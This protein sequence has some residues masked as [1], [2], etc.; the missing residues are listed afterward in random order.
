MASV[1][2]PLNMLPEDDGRVSDMVGVDG[3]DYALAFWGNQTGI[4]YDPSMIDA[5]DNVVAIAR[6]LAAFVW[7]IA[8]TVS[9]T[10][11]IAGRGGRS[12][13]RAPRHGLR[14]RR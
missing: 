14:R 7:A 6:E 9:I 1:F 12:G 10:L 2:M 8:T 5:A 13:R 3:G 11:L 4:A